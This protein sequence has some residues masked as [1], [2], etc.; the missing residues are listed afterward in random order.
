[1]DK[2]PER[3]QKIV[4]NSPKAKTY[5]SNGYLG[6]RDVIYW[7]EHFY[8]YN[9]NETYTVEGINSDLRKYIPFLQRKSKCFIRSFENARMVLT[10]F[11]HAYNKFGDEKYNFPKYKNCYSLTDFL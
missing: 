6:Y 4:D 1:M 8:H 9:K 7:G 3:I 5:H 10:I 2:E 11:M